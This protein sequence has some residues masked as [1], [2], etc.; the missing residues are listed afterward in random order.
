M[1]GEPQ[2]NLASFFGALHNPTRTI[3]K[4][5]SFA[6]PSAFTEASADKTAGKDAQ[7]TPRRR[8]RK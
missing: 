7:K 6:K 5:P 2:M 1:N 3:F 8:Q 4:S